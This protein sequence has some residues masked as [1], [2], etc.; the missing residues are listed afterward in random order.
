M[1]MHSTQSLSIACGYDRKPTGILRNVQ[2]ITIPKT[3]M[4]SFVVE[5]AK[6]HAVAYERTGLSDFA[7]AITRMAGD[8]GRPMR[9]RNS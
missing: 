2:S 5:L 4:A 8:E 9:S 6:Q 1:V 3:G 7:R